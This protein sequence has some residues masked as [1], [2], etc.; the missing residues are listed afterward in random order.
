M[1]VIGTRETV[2]DIDRQQLL[3]FMSE[4]YVGNNLCVVAAGSL[5]HGELVT[6][7]KQALSGVYSLGVEQE[8]IAPVVNRQIVVLQR[9]LEQA[10]SVLA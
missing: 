8:A 7:V 2:D 3:N 9:D 5:D 6:F 10:I 1:P 4:R